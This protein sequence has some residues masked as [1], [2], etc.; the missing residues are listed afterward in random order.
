MRLNIII[1]AQLFI[2]FYCSPLFGSGLGLHADLR[3]TQFGAAVFIARPVGD[4]HAFRPTHGAQVNFSSCLGLKIFAIVPMTDFARL[5]SCVSF[6]HLSGYEHASSGNWSV[7]RCENF[8]L[9]SELLLLLSGVPTRESVY[10]VAGASVDH[11]H[12]CGLHQNSD[13]RI[14]DNAVIAGFGR[15]YRSGDV[16][17][18]VELVYHK[19]IVH[20]TETSVHPPRMDRVQLSYGVIF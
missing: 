6:A 17:F 15:S 16:R 5:R 8:S 2:F 19:T 14:I 1:R 20:D 10:V 12:F 11:V 18:S 7:V 4:L 9:E 3:D 13:L